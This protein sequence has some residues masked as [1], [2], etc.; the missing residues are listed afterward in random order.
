[1][2]PEM[3]TFKKLTT[4]TLAIVLLAAGCGS[5]GKK[6]AAPATTTAPAATTASAAT[7]ATTATAA[8]TA[9]T[10][11]SPVATAAG[12][13]N[14]GATDTGVSA[15]EIK[16]G[17]VSD[18][19]LVL[20]EIV[21]IPVVAS[22]VAMF[23]SV[24]DKGGIF[25]RKVSISKCDAAGDLTRFRGC[26][27]KLVEEDKVFSFITSITWGTG[28]V[29]ADLAKSKIP[30]FGSW[31]FFTSEWR[32]PWMFPTHMA[33]IHEAHANSLWVRD[34]LKPKTVGI[35]YL[36]IPED[37]SATEEMKKIYEKAGIKVVKE[38]PLEIT[39]P[40]LDADVIAMQTAKP[41]HI[42]HFAWSPPA[43]GFMLAAEKQGYWPPLGM[44][45]NHF[46]AEALGEFIGDYPL[47]GM[48]TITTF[49]V[50][51][52]NSEYLS[53]L[54]K[55]S[56]QTKLKI[57]HI[58]QSGY[59]GARIFIEAAKKAGPKLT[60]QSMIDAFESQPWDAGPGLGVTFTWGPSADARAKGTEAVA[61]DKLRCEY[62]FKYNASKA[63][64]QLNVWAPAPEGY[65]VCDTQD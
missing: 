6:A 3:R 2:R 49:K 34:K 11:T 12:G 63:S 54:D 39:D 16:L 58:T 62:Q 18:D 10:A 65:E 26:F 32:D 29:H 5:S 53:V 51:S 8:T 35:L 25:G 60:R 48:W 30:W 21:T 64:N 50:W 38:I 61:H 44:S 47:K 42:V 45:G 31:G 37:K 22:V 46:A 33:S 14:G 15:T 27:K 23:D 9:T 52:E 24:N 59:A 17:T 41:D 20:P 36:N 7:T 40:N 4:A 55:Y 56:P 28:E 13:D 57:H 43:V 19:G 1:M